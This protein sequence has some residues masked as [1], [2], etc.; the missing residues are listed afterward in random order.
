MKNSDISDAREKLKSLQA[1][2]G[3]NFNNE[4]LLFT[5][6][7]HKSAREAELLAAPYDAQ[8][9]EFL[10]DKVLSYILAKYL[11]TKYIDK[12][13][14]ALSKLI[15]MLGK[16]S[17]QNMV[18]KD[19]HLDEYIYME[20]NLRLNLDKTSILSDHLEALIAA[21]YLDSDIDT[22]EKFILDKYLKDANMLLDANNDFLNYRNILIEY[23]QKHG[24]DL[25]FTLVN[26]Y[27]PDNDKSFEYKAELDGHKAIATAKTKK[28]AKQMAS[29]KLAIEMNLIEWK[30]T[31]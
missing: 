19:L 26:E 2:I 1:I 8:S 28:A 10:G 12:D 29:K 17:Y 9:L 18:A 5:S 14:G 6:L 21:I 22:A 20:A 4:N 11:Y 16:A 15:A 3:Y 24:L 25:I 31:I 30:K 23:A 7:V 13:E 27:G